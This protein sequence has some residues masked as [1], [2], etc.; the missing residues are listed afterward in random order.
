[1]IPRILHQIWIGPSPRPAPWMDTWRTQN[2]GY[3]YVLW[4][5]ARVARERL[6]LA[7]QIAR[8]PEWAGKADLIRYEVLARYGGIYADADSSCVKPLEDWLLVNDSFACWESEDC[9]PG[10]LANGFL[11]A[12]RG[13]LLMKMLV[14]ACA[15]LD[16]AAGPA[17]LTT[18]PRLLT[19]LVV[20]SGYPLTVYPSHFALPEHFACPAYAGAGPVFATQ[21]WGSTKNLYPVRAAGATLGERAGQASGL[22]ALGVLAAA[23]VGGAA[24]IHY[25]AKWTRR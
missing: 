22:V 15:T 6:S 8:A 5:D 11:G 2:P 19:D 10:L 1:M 24:A 7:P 18:G 23:A 14:A 13:N 21:H 25:G 3:E 4:D 17:W 9:R 12:T 16:P 20:A